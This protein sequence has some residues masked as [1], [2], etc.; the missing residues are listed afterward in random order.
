VPTGT[1][2]QQGSPGLCLSM[3]GSPEMHRKHAGK[4]GVKLLCEGIEPRLLH[5][6]STC[7]T[8]ELNHNPNPEEEMFKITFCYT[9]LSM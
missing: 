5:M 7:C 1:A 2:G 3:P 6:V 8:A 9:V 4:G